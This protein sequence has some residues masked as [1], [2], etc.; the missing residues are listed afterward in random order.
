MVVTTGHGGTV[1][2]IE[3]S[4][5]AGAEKL[6]IT[7][8]E[9]TVAIIGCGAIGQA[10]A[11]KIIDKIGLL[12]VYDRSPQAAENLRREIIDLGGNVSIARSTFDA[13]SNSNLF[14]GAITS[15]FED[16][17]IPEREIFG[18]GVDDSQPPACLRIQFERKNWRVVWP[19]ASAPDGSK[20]LATV[21]N[22]LYSFG[23]AGLL[24]EKEGV[25]LS[26]W[27]CEMEALTLACSNEYEAKINGPVTPK[28]AERIWE[29]AQKT[30]FKLAPLQSFG[31]PVEL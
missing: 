26:T 15:S 28:E 17:E 4:L 13:L 18:F 20:R 30:G 6:G 19:I 24:A 1:A 11:R 16:C 31:T 12:V 23:P 21:D 27:G 2:L 25:N 7:L 10:T 5:I 8:S 29:L 9:E 22:S 14:V 3:Q